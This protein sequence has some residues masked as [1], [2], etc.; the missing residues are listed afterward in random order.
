MS[1][2]SIL[3]PPLPR[4]HTPYACNSSSIEY[5]GLGRVSLPPTLS[6]SLWEVFHCLCLICTSHKASTTVSLNNS[7]GDSWYHHDFLLPPLPWTLYPMHRLQTFILKLP[8]VTPPPAWGRCMC[9]LS[10]LHLSST[11]PPDAGIFHVP[12]VFLLPLFPVIFIMKIIWVTFT[13]L[14]IASG[15]EHD[16]EPN[17]INACTTSQ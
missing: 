17:S 7:C 2:Y 4:T 6:I 10:K 16:H 3:P 11:P 9:P 1:T 8:T 5:L 14:V 13:V 15:T 12:Y